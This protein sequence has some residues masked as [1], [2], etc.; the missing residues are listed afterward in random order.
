[1]RGQIG[2]AALLCASLA[3]AGLAGLAVAPVSAHVED[4]CINPPGIKPTS[5]VYNFYTIASRL[6]CDYGNIN[7]SC[8]AGVVAQSASTFS[9]TSNCRGHVHFNAVYFTAAALGFTQDVSYFMA[10][11][12]QAIDFVQYKGV[13]SCGRD[14]PNRFW[15]PPLRG[16]LRTAT[17]YGGT[18]RHLGVP[19]VGFAS[20]P[21]P[22]LKAL[23]GVSFPL[24]Q[25]AKTYNGGSKKG[26][27]ANFFKD[28]FDDYVGQ[29]PA[30]RPN[31]EDKFYEGSLAQGKKWA[32]GE[33]NLLC[34]GGFTTINPKTMSPFA[35]SQCPT[36]DEYSVD[37]NELQQGPIPLTGGGLQLGE[38]VIHFECSPN[39]TAPTYNVTKKIYVSELPA[40]LKAQAK[41][42]GYAKFADGSVV[43]ELIVRMGI[44]LHWVTDR[45]SHWYCTDAPGSG[46]VAVPKTHFKYDLVGD[47]FER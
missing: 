40:Y 18:N 44:F 33:T 11:F 39:C 31:L 3:L 34:N 12:A 7:A 30:L 26:C 20:A 36:G 41:Q 15:T 16:F 21:P 32:M 28:S 4:I 25:S 5:G 47:L 10:A 19:F 14:M 13:D 17:A 27:D 29:C 6:G 38:Q 22:L 45:A 23:D 24:Y 42:Y 2:R 46:V 9:D 1:M 43:P 8:V 35:G 37:T